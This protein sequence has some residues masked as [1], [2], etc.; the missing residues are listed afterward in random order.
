MVETALSQICI[1]NKGKKMK[2]TEK[3]MLTMKTWHIYFW[4]SIALLFLIVILES[5][6]NIDINI[7]NI[8]YNKET[9]LWWLTAEEFMETRWLWYGGAKKAISI[10]AGVCVGVF[11]ASFFLKPFR[12]WRKSM[13]LICLSLLFVPLAIGA[14][15]KMTDI[16]CPREVSIYGGPY[17][18]QRILEPQNP[19]NKN[20]PV[21]GLCYPAGHASGGFALMMLFFAVP[22]PKLRKWGLLLGLCVGWLMGGY[23]MV[24]GEHFLS[25]TLSTMCIAWAINLLIILVIEKFQKYIF[26]NNEYPKLL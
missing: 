12:I 18:Y 14:G 24:R 21:P 19:L 22:Y 13:V 3:P 5:Y 8:W 15:K 2:L 17:E 4:A 6:T 1:I 9:R 25:H 20:N 26:K 23:Q 7:Q 16:Y 11:I 10:F